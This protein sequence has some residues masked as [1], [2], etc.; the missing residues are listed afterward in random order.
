[1]KPATRLRIP[2]TYNLILPLFKKV[3][4][5][6]LVTLFGLHDMYTGM[7]TRMSWKWKIRGTHT[8]TDET[9]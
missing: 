8:L 1:M 7:L 3:I 9:E 6:S 2:C 5:S 4:M